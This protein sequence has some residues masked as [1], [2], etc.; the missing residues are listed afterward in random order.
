MNDPT[1]SSATANVAVANDANFTLFALKDI[2]CGDTLLI[3]Y[4]PVFWEVVGRAKEERKH[5]LV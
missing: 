1:G 4:G 3:D 2:K 5:L